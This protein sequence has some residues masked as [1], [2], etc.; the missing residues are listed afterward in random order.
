MSQTFRLFW[1]REHAC[2]AGT[3]VQAAALE[4]SIRDR[5][6]QLTKGESGEFLVRLPFFDRREWRERD[7]L[8]SQLVFERTG[9]LIR[10]VL[11]APAATRDLA[12]TLALTDPRWKSAPVPGEQNYDSTWHRVSL[13]IQ[14][15]LRSW[16]AREFLADPAR[17]EDRAAG[18]SV[19]MYQASRPFQGRNRARGEFAYDMRA[20]PTNRTMLK[21]ALKLTGRA[22]QSA[23]AEFERVLLAAGKPE[24]ARRYAPLWYEDVQV[25]VRQRPRLLVQ[26]LA[27]DATVVNAVVDLAAEP[28][29]TNVN[30]TARLINGAL[31]NILGIDMRKLGVLVFEEATSTLERIQQGGGEDL[32]DA[33]PPE[34][35]GMPSAGRPHTWVGSQEDGQDGSTHG[36]GEMRDS[37]IIANVQTRRGEPAGE[38][39]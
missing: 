10:C 33:R 22:T 35:A 24:L 12:A 34:H 18:Y 19:A 17:C 2:D 26:L 30:R 9:N 38:F 3:P 28:S 7:T 11:S 31:R 27:A 20:Y 13:A 32:L 15:G 4:Y 1:L 29:C 21:E 37:G 25:A 39:I 8:L 14:R 23:L 5:I 36:S 16:I 6:V